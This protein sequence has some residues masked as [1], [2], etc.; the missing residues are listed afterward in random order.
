MSFLLALFF[1]PL[2]WIILKL[3]KRNNTDSDVY[4]RNLFLVD[5]KLS[6]KQLNELGISKFALNKYLRVIRKRRFV[7]FVFESKILIYRRIWSRIAL[8]LVFQACV[9]LISLLSLI[10]CYSLDNDQKG[11]CFLI[12]WV[13]GSVGLTYFYWLYDLRARM[14]DRIFYSFNDL[15]HFNREKVFLY[16]KSIADLLD[17]NQEIPFFLRQRFNESLDQILYSVSLCSTNS[18]Y[19]ENL[20][21][22]LSIKIEIVEKEMN[23]ILEKK[24]KVLEFFRKILGFKFSS[25]NKRINSSAFI[26]E[27]K[28]SISNLMKSG[29]KKSRVEMDPE[30]FEGMSLESIR[31]IYDLEP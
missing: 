8:F 4:G 31:T 23:S 28:V 29:S 2:D 10:F 11:T 20:D 25:D 3:S 16:K 26:P 6:Q 14:L 9:F 24:G 15:S 22:A 19:S 13:F 12:F 30:L 18:T 1:A 7:K 17:L 27:E 21:K 5:P